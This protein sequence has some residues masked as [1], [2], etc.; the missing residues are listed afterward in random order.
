MKVQFEKIIELEKNEIIRAFNKDF[1]PPVIAIESIELLMETASLNGTK[2]QEID[3]VRTGNGY[4]W[5][6]NGTSSCWVKANYKGYR[7]AYKKYIY[8]IFEF[9]EKIPSEYDIDH[10]F[11]QGRG[12]KLDT[13][14]LRLFPVL[15]KINRTHGAIFENRVTKSESKRLM[16]KMHFMTFIS[17]LKILSIIPPKS[18][19][20]KDE[21]EKVS[22][23]IS[24]FGYWTKD[25]VKK[26]LISL[27]N[28][29]EH[30]SDI[31][32]SQISGSK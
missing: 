12:K 24:S 17:F 8:Q 14:Y 9:K 11:N 23:A 21:L 19:D 6:Y 13:G 31:I 25:D 32:I 26:S 3:G 1:L 18:I 5:H 28:R 10:L 20:E 4:I 29:I 22:V 15:K 7:N 30:P 2:L 16:K 27:I